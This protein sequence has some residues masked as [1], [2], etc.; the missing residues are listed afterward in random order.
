MREFHFHAVV[1]G[2]LPSESRPTLAFYCST[3]RDTKM[4]FILKEE[5]QLNSD[6]GYAF[7][8]CG[9]IDLEP[10]FSGLQ[11]AAPVHVWGDLGDQ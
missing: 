7:L 11:Y 6:T 1:D 10:A 3:R 4:D 5:G 8:S 2:R 9:L